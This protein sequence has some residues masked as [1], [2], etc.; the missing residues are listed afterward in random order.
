MLKRV[1]ILGI[2]FGALVSMTYDNKPCGKYK[3]RNLYEGQQGG[4]YY[5]KGKEH[6]KIYVNKKYCKC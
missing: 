4:C 6:K 2:A 1:L 3:N 5:L